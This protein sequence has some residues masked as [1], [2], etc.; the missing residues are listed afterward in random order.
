[1]AHFVPL[2]NQKA[3]EIALA[4]VSEIWRL[5]GIPKRVVSDWDTLFMSSFW[6]EVMRLIEVEQD[7]SSAYHSQTNVQTE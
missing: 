4:F 3:S 7:K 6:T 2:K 1:M 5:H